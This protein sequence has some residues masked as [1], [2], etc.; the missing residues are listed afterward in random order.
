MV[1]QCDHEKCIPPKRAYYGPEYGNKYAHRCSIHKEP[2]YVRSVKPLC[3][4]VYEN[5]TR[6]L[7]SPSFSKNDGKKKQEYCSKHAPKNYINIAKPLCIFVD[8]LGKRCNLTPS[9]AKGKGQKREYCSKH[10]PVKYEDFSHKKCIICNKKQASCGPN[11]GSKNAVRCGDCKLSTDIVC[12]AKYCVVC[13]KYI[14]SFGTK[15]KKPLRCSYCK[16]PSDIDVVHKRCVICKIN[17]ASF[18]IKIG[19]N[20]AKRCGNCKLENDIY[21]HKKICCVKE[22]ELSAIYGNITQS[23]KKHP[24]RCKIHKNKSDVDCVN[25][26]CCINDCTNV[27]FWKN[28]DTIKR[29]CIKHKLDNDVNINIKICEYHGCSN[30]AKFKSEHDN[31]NKRC[32]DHKIVNDIC[33]YETCVYKDCYNY[34]IYGYMTDR[35]KRCKDHKL[36]TDSNLRRRLCEMDNCGKEVSYGPKHGHS[37]AIRCNVHAKK[38]DVN[39]N[40]KLCEI[41]NTI[42]AS[43]GK[44][45]GHK[46][47]KRCNKHK[48]LDDINVYS[49]VCSN[50]DCKTLHHGRYKLCWYCRPNKYIK[51]RELRVVKYLKSSMFNEFKHDTISAD[52]PRVCGKY[53]PDILYDFGTHFV[54]VEVDEDQH[55][56][57]DANCEMKRMMSILRG[58]GL[59]TVFIRYNPDKY[60]AKNIAQKTSFAERMNK[61]IERIEF[62][63]TSK[64]IKEFQIEY[65]FYDEC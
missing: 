16:L 52:K 38:E 61:L 5:G 58:L 2:G 55:K 49:K 41:C 51:Y 13:S 37:N 26:L 12:T 33:S 19:A 23:G 6:C 48:N 30:H 44:A 39:C 56:Q 21:C 4:Y 45:L 14:A 8:D 43:F 53:R 42:K 34:P 10:A 25:I 9:F 64:N 28:D 32:I 20:Y 47:A 40:D 29:R 46:Y 24:V 1:K 17:G 60:T 36:P 7:T 15:I 50:Q 3:V 31:F 57:Y 54:I 65:L 27:G 22:C 63:K 62:Y 18:G 35:R 11:P 59:P